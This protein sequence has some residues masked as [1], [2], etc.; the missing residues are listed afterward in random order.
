MMNY[1]GE[2]FQV[3]FGVL[4]IID[5]IGII[6]QFLAVTANY[7]NKIR[8]HIIRR[9]IMVAAIV[10]LVFVVFGNV[11]L[12]FFGITPGAFYI[13]G[14]ILFFTIS[15]EMIQSK[16][17]VRNTPETAIDPQDAMM[18]AV[19]PIAIPLIAGP[20]MI[21]TI[22]LKVSA[23]SFGPAACI[24]LLLSLGTGLL[25]EYIAMRSGALILRFIGTTGMF[26]I[27]KI[28]GLILAGMSI[29]LIYDGLVKLNIVK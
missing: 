11:M 18:T 3:L 8:R 26:V 25:L 1:I 5:P 17:R 9:S 10:M 16:P 13:S 14:G 21:T 15:F 6:P 4:I 24:I 28:M 22:M 7:D 19:F 12:K 2:F 20:G 23:E 27:E 29:Q